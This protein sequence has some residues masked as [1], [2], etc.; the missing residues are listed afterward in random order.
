[1]YTYAGVIGQIEKFLRDPLGPA[2]GE[3]RCVR[4]PDRDHRKRRKLLEH[5][6]W[7]SEGERAG[8]I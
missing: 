4:V 2:G 6:H 1:M 5:E 3:L 8:V 7:H